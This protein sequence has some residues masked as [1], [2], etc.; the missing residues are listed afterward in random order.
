MAL[1]MWAHKLGFRLCFRRLI[2]KRV[3]LSFHLLDLLPWAQEVVAE[4]R[5]G[6]QAL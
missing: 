2:L 6:D 5:R 4:V 3:R 1:V